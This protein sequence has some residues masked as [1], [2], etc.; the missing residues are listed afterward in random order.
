MPDPPSPS[1]R[2]R[3]LIAVE[4]A[5]APVSA[6]GLAEA[7]DLHPSTVRFHLRK[8]VAAGDITEDTTPADGRGRPSKVYRPA[9]PRPTDTLLSALVAALGDDDADRERRAVTAGRTWAAGVLPDAPPD[10]SD[11]LPDPLEIAATALTRLGFE[12][13]AMG[14]MFGVHELRVCSCPLRGLAAGHPEVARGIQRGAVEQALATASP[15][16]PEA[17]S[18]SSRPDPRYGDCEVTIRLAPSTSTPTSGTPTG[19]PTEGPARP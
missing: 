15:G 12:I 8:L 17:Y 7:L 19:A 4:E 9:P 3:V 14:S 18:V 10:A 13:Q 16:L 1:P 2:G 5:A 6:A 11:G